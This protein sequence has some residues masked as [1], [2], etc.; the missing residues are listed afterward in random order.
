MLKNKLYIKI[1]TFI[2]CFVNPSDKVLILKKQKN[3]F[4]TKYFC[5]IFLRNNNILFHSIYSKK[6]FIKLLNS[7]REFIYSKKNLYY[8]KIILTGVGY[9]FNLIKNT[10]N[11]LK[12]NLG[13]SH[14]IYIKIPD[15]ISIFYINP[16]IIYLSSFDYL[17]L[18]N[19]SNYIKKFRVPEPY[20]GKGIKFEYDFIKI[21]EGK[22]NLIG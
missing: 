3:V 10:I 1:P 15:E 21:K 5:K 11:I 9:R 20:K 8:K 14:P 7:I 19:I 12:L 13:Y 17:K 22:K 18:N 4:I 16:T 6:K 2:K